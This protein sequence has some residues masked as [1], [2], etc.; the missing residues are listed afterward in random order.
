MS[1][2]SCMF[3]TFLMILGLLLN[4]LLKILGSLLNT[5][6]ED[7]SGFVSERPSKASEHPSEDDSGF[8]FEHSF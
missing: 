1:H 2:V 6:S 3:F 8:A 5:A 4:T 7:D